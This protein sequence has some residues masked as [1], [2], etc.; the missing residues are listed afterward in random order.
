M[1][2]VDILILVMLLLYVAKGFSNGVIKEGVTFIGGLAVI[3]ISFLL[4]NPISVFM[5]QNLPFFKFSGILSGISV[6]NIIIY[7]IIAFLI[8]A[9]VLLTIYRLVIKV[10]NLLETILK[11]TFVLALPSKIL[12]AVVGF[13]EGIVFV[14]LVLFVCMQFD[15]TRSKIEASKYGDKILADTPILGS[16]I[17]PVY[18]SLKEIYSVAENYKD[19]TD[20]AEANLK[21]FDVLLK[22]KVISPENADVLVKSGKLNMPGADELVQKYWGNEKND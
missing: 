6:L 14:F 10:T 4:K 22:Y 1:N 16:A 17:S 11:L 20:K 19:A 7:E 5:Y 12:G 2:V 9:A 13:I 18:D 21:S 8:V 15:M 3:V